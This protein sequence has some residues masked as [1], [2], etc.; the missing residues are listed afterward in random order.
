MFFIFQDVHEIFCGS[1]WQDSLNFAVS[2]CS[3]FVPLVTPRY[4]ETQWTNREV[5][6]DVCQSKHYIQG[7]MYRS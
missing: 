6:K 3:V 7:S 1:D 4:G 5:C 2:H